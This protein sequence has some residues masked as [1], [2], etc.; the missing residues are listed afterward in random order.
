MEKVALLIT[1][2]FRNTVNGISVFSNFFIE[3]VLMPGF[4]KVVVIE[5]STGNIFYVGIEDYQKSTIVI[6][7]IYVNANFSK[8]D[9][10]IRSDNFFNHLTKLGISAVPDP[11]KILISHGWNRIQLRY[12]YYWLYY[13]I[14]NFFRSKDLKR[15]NFYNEVI[16][17]STAKDNFRHTD[18]L[19]CLSKNIKTSFYDFTNHFIDRT[20]NQKAPV[21]KP[22]I[23]EHNYILL[24]ANFEKIKNLWWII[25]YNIRKRARSK[26][27]MKK[28]VVLVKPTPGIG[29]SIFRFCAKYLSIQ[30]VNN[31]EYKL[32]LLMNCD[33]LFIPSYSEYNPVVGLEAMV[34]N[35]KVVS[36]YK[37]QAMVDNNYYHY[38]K[39]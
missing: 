25:S 1:D 8:S 4:N 18:Y 21:V 35:K 16:F 13:Y 9:L 23:I 36:L 32:P 30:I 7:S 29:Y 31:Q 6:D 3:D 39:N 19:Y 34:Y 22:H 33:Y 2:S 26:N 24:I 38:L 28:F 5:G 20:K 14:K 15:L 10:H 12:S 11:K 27:E 37:I 17:I